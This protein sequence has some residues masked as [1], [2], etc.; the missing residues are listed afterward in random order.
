MVT[1]RS[2]MDPGYRSDHSL[3]HAKIALSSQ[4]RGRGTFNNSLLYDENYVKFVKQCIQ[5]VVNQY[6]SNGQDEI[7]DPANI[8]FTIDDQIFLEMLRLMIRGKTIPYTSR[9]KKERDNNEKCLLLVLEIYNQ[10]RNN[11]TCAST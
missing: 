8:Q 10:L 4:L 11:E 7:T 9:K 2:H 6:K 5:D 3:C 1:A